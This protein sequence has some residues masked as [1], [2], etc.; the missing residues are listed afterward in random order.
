MPTHSS[1]SILI[2]LVTREADQAS[3]RL[4]M[5]IQAEE[6]ASRK[7]AL[8]EHYKENYNLGFKQNMAIGI[9]IWKYRNYQ[10]FL[11]NIERAIASQQEVL[12]R[13]HDHVVTEREVWQVI[14]RKRMSY[15]ILDEQA[16]QRKLY[17]EN[18]REQKLTDEHAMRQHQIR[19][20]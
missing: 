4:G 7:L 13:T 14:E 6:E 17:A 3:I 18:K 16:A 12:R 5:A 9:S 20:S 19:K 2:E 11:E 15:K 1:L 8:L 10:V